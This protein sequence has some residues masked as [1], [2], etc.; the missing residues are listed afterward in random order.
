[1]SAAGL[2]LI[3]PQW[4]APAN[5][6]AMVTTRHGG[7]SQSPYDSLNLADHVGDLPAA[8]LHNRKVLQKQLPVD[9][10]I[11]WLEQVHGTQLAEPQRGGEC[12]PIADGIYLS[13]P[14]TAGAVLTADC[15]PVFFS[16][17]AG[18]EAAVAHAGWRGLAAGILENT[19]K[20]FRAGG[21]ALTAWLGPAIGPCHFEVG[22]E[23]RESFLS[24][25]SS[26]SQRRR[27]DEAAFKPAAAPGKWMADLYEI[28]RLRL[29]AAGVSRISGGQL[30]TFCEPQ[31]FYSYRRDGGTGRMASLICIRPA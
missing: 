22:A 29:S 1:M 12:L 14:N 16:S 18:D 4:E 13:E 3:M 10:A 30:C 23:V 25:C 15:L 6:L 26:D 5:V 2:S 17:L 24:A 7:F 27:M 20:R 31:R 21:D 8:V 11:Q 9:V 19:V 28:A